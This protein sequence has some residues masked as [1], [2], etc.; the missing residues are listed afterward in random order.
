MWILTGDKKETALNIGR[1]CRLI[2]EVGKNELNFTTNKEYLNPK[3]IETQLAYEE[4][5]FV[6][7]HNKHISNH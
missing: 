6:Y 4:N 7:I 1:S 3:E 2:E 5:K